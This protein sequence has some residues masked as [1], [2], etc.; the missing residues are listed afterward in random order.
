MRIPDSVLA[1]KRGDPG[2]R[3]RVKFD[4]Q[5]FAKSL[6][7]ICQRNSFETI[8]VL[9]LLNI[10]CSGR[11]WNLWNA[12]SLPESLYDKTIMLKNITILKFCV[13]YSVF[14]I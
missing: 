2:G 12:A 3:F 9:K 6:S 7:A 14:S 4:L 1:S 5:K 13:Y 8:H 10:Y 11:E